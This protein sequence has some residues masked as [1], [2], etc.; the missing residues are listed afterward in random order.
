MD[1]TAPKLP[2]HAKPMAS[3]KNSPRKS[4]YTV[5]FPSNMPAALIE[6]NGRSLQD[7][8]EA[9]S[10]LSQLSMSSNNSVVLK[11]FRN[12][13]RGDVIALE[14]WTHQQL[15][16]IHNKHSDDPV[17]AHREKEKESADQIKVLDASA[18]L[19]AKMI[20]V[21]CIDK[22]R[23]LRKLWSSSADL[24]SS[25]YTELSSIIHELKLKLGEK[26]MHCAR[27]EET[28]NRVRTAVTPGALMSSLS[29]QDR[30]LIMSSGRG[31]NNNTT[32]AVPLS[33][34]ADND[35]IHL[36][37]AELLLKN[38]EMLQLQSTLTSLAVWFPNFAKFNT[39][40][41]S[42]YLPP[43]DYLA[44]LE[45]AEKEREAEEKRL[46]QEKADEEAR[47]AL[48][49]S[50]KS[51][52]TKHRATLQAIGEYRKDDPNHPK[53]ANNV[54]TL[55]QEMQDIDIAQNYLLKDLK[56]LQGLGVGFAV[57]DPTEL[58]AAKNAITQSMAMQNSVGVFANPAT[59]SA[60]NTTNTTN[61]NTSP[62]PNTN[63]NTNTNNNSNAALPKSV[64][65]A[66]GRTSIAVTTNYRSRLQQM[67]SFVE[68]QGDEYS[69][70]P[71][72]A[73]PDSSGGDG[74]YG[75]SSSGG[76]AG[77]VSVLCCVWAVFNASYSW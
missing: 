57:L 72:D 43:I 24:F 41:L 48:L 12:G 11:E 22:A 73:R 77:Q 3:F 25:I 49:L 32:T 16:E 60:T 55:E 70:A 10:Q 58:E 74:N 71:V 61:T 1:K 14:A 20:E 59:T 40:I 68:V 51:T 23:L 67:K 15:S 19:L 5:G 66:L 54:G 64:A 56:R 18:E 36:L 52:S 75:G 13:S 17:S 28:M 63:T 65:A 76:T 30:E 35:T 21:H 45:R 62:T 53:K 37:E 50:P 6:K 38:Q 2:S 31:N 26:N 7:K 27:L 42:K 4:S 29:P 46:Q 47:Q 8:S 33:N 69:L 39:S 9:L 44:E 34:S